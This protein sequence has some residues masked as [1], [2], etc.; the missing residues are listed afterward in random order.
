MLLK[1]NAGKRTNIW[2][3]EM[4]ICTLLHAV[5]SVSE[6]SIYTA[7][8]LIE[9]EIY[10]ILDIKWSWKQNKV[11]ITSRVQCWLKFSCQ[12]SYLYMSCILHHLITHRDALT[13]C[14]Y[15]ITQNRMGWDY[16]CARD[17]DCTKNFI[18]TYTFTECMCRRDFFPLNFISLRI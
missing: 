2:S 10:W 12:R 1:K 13:L 8:A 14:A 3:S 15:D 18:R 4:S 11:Y 17:L 6:Y 5:S 7:H 16:S 9:A